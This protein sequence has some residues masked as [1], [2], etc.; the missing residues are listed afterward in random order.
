LRKKKRIWRSR[1]F[2]D[3]PFRVLEAG[4][5]ADALAAAISDPLVKRLPPIGAADQFMDSTDALGDLRYPRAVIT[6]S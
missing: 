5:F 3:R 1:L 4:R 2:F 6:A